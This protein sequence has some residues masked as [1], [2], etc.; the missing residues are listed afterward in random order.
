MW[1]RKR[2][3]IWLGVGLLFG[4]F[5]LYP[6]ARDEGGQT[7]WQYFIQL[8]TLLVIVIAVMFYVYSRKG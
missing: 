8:E 7:D 5:F 3:L 1:D 2:Q 6:L 4:S